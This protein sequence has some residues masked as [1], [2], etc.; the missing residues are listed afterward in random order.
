MFY[1]FVN[2]SRRLQHLFMSYLLVMLFGFL[3]FWYLIVLILSYRFL[4]WNWKREDEPVRKR[5]CKCIIFQ[6]IM[7]FQ[8]LGGKEHF[9]RLKLWMGL[10]QFPFGCLRNVVRFVSEVGMAILFEIPP[11]IQTELLFVIE[12]ELTFNC[13]HDLNINLILT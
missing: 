1:F 11:L 8:A 2:I 3:V 5:S 9:S 6:R 7:F 4:F 10:I 13:D 12:Q